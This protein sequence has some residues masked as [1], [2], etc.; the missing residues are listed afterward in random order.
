MYSSEQKRRA[1]LMQNCNVLVTVC[2]DIVVIVTFLIGTPYRGA[3]ASDAYATTSGAHER[4]SPL[5]DLNVLYQ[6]VVHSLEAP[7]SQSPATVSTSS[8]T[9]NFIH[10]YG[11]NTILREKQKQQQLFGKGEDG[12]LIVYGDDSN[13]S[14]VKV[15]RFSHMRQSFNFTRLIVMEG[16]TLLLEFDE[17]INSDD[18][19]NYTSVQRN[20]DSEFLSIRASEFIYVGGSIY[21]DGNRGIES[22]GNWSEYDLNASIDTSNNDDLDQLLQVTKH[23]ISVLIKIQQ[24]KFAFKEML[25]C[26]FLQIIV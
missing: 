14:N 11:N 26:V 3:L 24:V 12:A 6:P 22:S 25:T 9:S 13:T 19:V 15:L 16:A 17:Q 20:S 4:C 1:C 18:N 10:Q 8:L 21:G 5:S 2:L 23:D 7:A